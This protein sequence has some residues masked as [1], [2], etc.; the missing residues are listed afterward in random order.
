MLPIT[1]PETEEFNSE[2]NEFTVVPAVSLQLEHS[3]ISMSKW[4]AKW[5]KSFMSSRDLTVD[6]LIDYV[7]CM[8]INKI[9]DQSAYSRLTQENIEDIRRYIDDPMTA[10]TIREDGARGG[11]NRII[12]TEQI[13]GWMVGYGIPFDPC[14]KWHLNRLM[15]LIR[16]CSVQQSGGNRKMSRREQAAW[17]TAQNAKRRA[18]TGSRG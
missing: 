13:Y 3:L 12:T 18:R 4:E 9:S 14:E 11:R 1:V 15:M 8:T 16:V 10:T 6:E 2:T 7:R 5:K 17:Q